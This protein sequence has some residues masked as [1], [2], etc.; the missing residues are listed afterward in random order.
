MRFVVARHCYG[1][2]GDHLS[3][4]MGAWW[5]AKRTNRTL[6]VDWRGSRFN[7]DPSLE[8]NCFFS[9]F[10]AKQTIGGVEIVA[11]NSVG[12]LNYPLPV[13]PPKWTPTALAGSGHVNHSA[14]EIAQ[15]NKLMSSETDPLEP[16]IVFNQWLDPSPPREAVRLFLRDLRPVEPIADAAQRFW[17]AQIGKAPA[18]GIHIRHG[19][20]ENLGSRAAYWLGSVALIRQLVIN[21]RNDVHKKGISGRFSDNMPPS[22][23]GAPDQAK[24]ERRFCRKVA[25]AFDSLAI[26]DAV[27]ILF[28]DAGHIIE[29]MRE[30]LPTVVAKPKREVKRGE[31][32]LHQINAASVRQDSSGIRG[33]T[34]SDDIVFDMFVE[35]ELMRRCSGLVFMDSGFSLLARTSMDENRLIRLKPSLTNRLISRI[36][37]RMINGL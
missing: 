24:Y 14:A 32:P 1:G 2:I 5:L 12:L 10:S 20:G 37:G 4:V 22:L 27:P 6:V 25:E 17:D 30:F 11:D 7:P 35:L 15:A 9:Y 33:G 3:C 26:P 34:I 13:W 8:S 29:M 36:A 16:T 23:I 31:G 21:A 19:N 18:V 28:S